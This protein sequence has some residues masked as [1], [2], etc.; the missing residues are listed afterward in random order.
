MVCGIIHCIGITES[1]WLPHKGYDCPD[2]H[3]KQKGKT[4]LCD[5]ERDSQINNHIVR[6][7]LALAQRIIQLELYGRLV[8]CKA[9]VAESRVNLLLHKFYA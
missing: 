3:K 1:S 4:D 7:D 6:Y 5:L 9:S 8:I 2:S